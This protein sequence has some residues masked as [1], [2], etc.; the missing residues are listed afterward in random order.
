[1]TLGP[2]IFSYPGFPLFQRRR[3][4]L[5]FVKSVCLLYRRWVSIKSE[6]RFCKRFSNFADLQRYS[7]RICLSRSR[8]YKIHLPT[9]QRTYCF[10]EI[11]ESWIWGLFRPFW[12]VLGPIFGI[13]R[14]RKSL[15]YYIVGG[16]RYFWVGSKT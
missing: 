1:M 6:F 15:I 11:R 3:I 7:V 14:I 10:L 12:A 4:A 16:Y 8:F 5:G 2:Y 9:K 13:L